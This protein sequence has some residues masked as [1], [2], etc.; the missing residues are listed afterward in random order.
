L[1]KPNIVM[2]FVDDLGYGDVGFNGHPTTTTPNI[3]KLAI[4]G[5]VLSTWYSGCPVCSGSR[6]ALMTGRQ[7]TRTGVPGVFGPTVATGLPLNETTVAG[8]LKKAGYATAA[9]GKWHLGQRPMFLPTARGF[10]Y[11][12][13]IPYSDDMGSGRVTSC[14]NSES[15]E[16]DHS[17][18]ASWEEYVAAG[19]THPSDPG[20]ESAEQLALIDAVNVRASPGALLPLVYQSPGGSFPGHTNTTVLEQPLDF[21]HLAEHYT[22]Y[23]KKF[24]SENKEKPF[25]LYMPFSHVHTTRNTAEGQYAG[26][27]FRNT[28]KRGMFGDALAEVDW[29]VGGVIDA[30]EANGVS[31]NTLTLFTGDNG[32]WMIKGKSGGSTGLLTGE[33]SGYWN[34]GKGSTWEGGIHEAGFAH[35]PGQI[36]PFSRS[37]EVVSSLDLFPTVSA[38]AGLALPAGVVYDGR[39]MSDVLLGTNGGKSKHTFLFFYGGA[40]DGGRGGSK[41]PTAVRHGKYKA[42][43]GT[44]P[45]LGGAKDMPRRKYPDYPLLFNVHEDPSEEYPL[46]LNC[47]NGLNHTSHWRWEMCR[48][49]P[50]M[51]PTDPELAAVIVACNKAFDHEVATFQYGHLSTPALLPTEEKGKAGICC[52]A[53]KDGGTLPISKATC[54]C[55]GSIGP[56][57][58]APGPMPPTPSSGGKKVPKENL[59]GC[60]NDHKEKGKTAHNTGLCDLN[61]TVVASFICTNADPAQP[62]PLPSSLHKTMTNEVCN[63]FCQKYKYFGT[64]SGGSCHCG[65]SYG[66]MGKAADGKCS[67]ACAGDKT[68]MCGGSDLNTV[69]KVMVL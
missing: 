55:S 34:T 57:S 59:L 53:T 43:W 64:Q 42:H 3:N 38:L 23:T 44:G 49:A 41:G 68:E 17:G 30:L 66:S 26:C 58:P 5:K 27:L 63:Q 32:P 25:F 47:T 1:D 54:D 18:D 21:T 48:D 22:A 10:D 36:A 8:Q 52:D 31:E 20:P 4:G 56:P 61:A 28:S 19:Y 6:A 9:M 45:G 24:I 14:N 46:N 33:F 35:W 67:E 60:Y 29:I 65:N 51:L 69:Y 50:T 16:D 11:Y 2:L 37:T 7:Y 13:G 15:D 39:D 40:G 62:G 12:M